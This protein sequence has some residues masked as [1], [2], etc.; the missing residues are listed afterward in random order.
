ME[1]LTS[2][3]K[4]HRINDYL[5]I[6]D[7]WTEQEFKEN[8]RLSRRSAL[9]LIGKKCMIREKYSM[10][11]LRTMSDRFDISISSIFRILRRVEN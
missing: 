8:L 7:L 3:S 1:H 6:V 10:I 9:H 4:R 2:G 11:S 5:E